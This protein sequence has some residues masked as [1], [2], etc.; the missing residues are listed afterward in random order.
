MPLLGTISG[1]RW[2][3]S[4]PDRLPPLLVHASAS[5]Q[6]RDRGGILRRLRFGREYSQAEPDALSIYFGGCVSV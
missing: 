6:R 5:F 3:L 4:V 2:E 1:L